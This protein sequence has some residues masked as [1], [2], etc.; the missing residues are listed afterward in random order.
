MGRAVQEQCPGIPGPDRPP[1]RR[2]N[3]KSEVYQTAAVPRP[4]RAGPLVH[5]RALC[6]SFCDHE[7]YLPC[8]TMRVALDVRPALSRPTGVGVYIGAL[9][10]LLPRLDPG[11]RFTL[12]TSSLRERWTHPLAGENVDL[13]DRRVPVQVLNLT[14]NRLSWP[15][16]E[17]LCGRD[18]DIAHSPHALLTPTRRARQ[19]I[20]IHDLF[21]FAT[22][23]A[24]WGITPAGPPG[25]SAPPS[26]A[27]AMWS[28]C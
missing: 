21:F 23:P 25:S 26:T 7:L 20:S 3:E 19:I 24:S 28:G 17:M 10:G 1:V 22:T 4:A 27:L 5:D 12:F 16:L 13:I 2:L 14:W 8:P 6:I 11:S 18:F 15:P 9:A